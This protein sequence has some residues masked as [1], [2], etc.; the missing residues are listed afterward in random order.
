L[1]VQPDGKIVVAGQTTPAGS[2]VAGLALARYTADGALDPTFGS[3]GKVITDFGASP[4]ERA[5]ALALQPDGKVLVAGT[6]YGKNGNSISDFV[7]MRF[8]S[9]GTPDPNFGSGGK[10]TTDFGFFT[11]DRAYA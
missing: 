11:Y 10:V 2:L 3:G 5:F 4:V 9:D 6:T 7:V 1:T 8:G